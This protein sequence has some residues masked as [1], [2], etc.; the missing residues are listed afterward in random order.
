MKSLP[1]SFKPRFQGKQRVQE[2]HE[3]ESRDRDESYQLSF[4]Q[5]MR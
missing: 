5:L 3:K 2:T 1:V 4:V